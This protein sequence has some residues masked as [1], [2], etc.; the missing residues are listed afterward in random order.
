MN[1]KTESDCLLPRSS[2]SGGVTCLVVFKKYYYDAQTGKCES[3]M[4]EGC[5]VPG[6]N[7]ETLEEC[8]TICG[9]LKDKKP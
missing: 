4:L 1:I 5:D 3:F 6:N 9:G 8:Q 2:A 7:F